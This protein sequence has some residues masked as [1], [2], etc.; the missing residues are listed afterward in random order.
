MK[1]ICKNNFDLET[2]N[3]RLIA[4]N[5]GEFYAKDITEF[6]NKKYGGYTSPDYFVIVPDD[7]KLYVW[8]P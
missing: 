7:Y 1:I 2:V 4:E 6:L 8:E 3:D 5:V